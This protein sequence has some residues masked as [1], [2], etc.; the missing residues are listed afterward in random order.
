MHALRL[1]RAGWLLLGLVI[2]AVVWDAP[3]AQAAS[4]GGTGM[5][6]EEPILKISNSLKGPVAFGIMVMAMVGA[7]AGLV[8]GQEI[9]G[10][11]RTMLMVVLAGSLLLLGGKLMAPLFGVGAVVG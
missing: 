11:I 5:P 1:S 7:G 4:S 6:W 3:L 10:F 2:M 8:M 9:S